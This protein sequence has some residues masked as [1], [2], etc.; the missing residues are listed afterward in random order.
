MKYVDYTKFPERP[1]E[2]FWPFQVK[3]HK[4]HSQN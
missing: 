1:G 3:I 2:F 4:Q